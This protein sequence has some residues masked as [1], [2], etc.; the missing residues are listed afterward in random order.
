MK[1]EISFR[2]RTFFCSTSKGFSK[3][4]QEQEAYQLPN[5]NRE[6]VLYDQFGGDNSSLKFKLNFEKNIHVIFNFILCT[7]L[8]GTLQYFFGNEKKRPKNI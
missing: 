3:M 6:V 5:E 8:M 1:K 4:H 7:F 2:R